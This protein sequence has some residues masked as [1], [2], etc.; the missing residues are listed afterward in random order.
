[1][2]DWSRDFAGMIAENTP[3]WAQRLEAEIARH[4]PR[5]DDTGA[6]LAANWVRLL[7]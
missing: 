4:A 7:G 2:R 1:M 5:A 6:R 3:D